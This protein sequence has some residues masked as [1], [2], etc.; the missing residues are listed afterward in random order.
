MKRSQDHHHQD[1]AAPQASRNV[2][3]PHHEH[4]HGTPDLDW[5]S[6]APFL[7]NEAEALASV[8]QQAAARVAE[9]R[10]AAGIRRILDIGSG[11]GVV[12]C[13]L[14]EAFPEAEV[15]AVDSTPALLERTRERAQRLGVAGRV[16]TLKAEV[17]GQ[18]DEL[19]QADLI[20]MGNSL[21]HIGD[22]RAALAA[23]AGLLRPGGALLLVEG[24][25]RARHLP[26]DFGIGRTGLEARL[27]AV[28][29]E[30]FA[31]MRASLP[32]AKEEI[33]DWAQLFTDAGLEPVGTRSY[34]ADHPAPIGASV[35]ELAIAGF[36]RRRDSMA[37]RLSR[38]DLA[39]LDRLL[40]PADPQ[41]LANRPDVFMLT[42][43]SVHIGL[44][45][46]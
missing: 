45:K 27:E 15:V 10:P 32:G 7:E 21:H 24:G 37:D 41:G 22:Q 16:R 44:A 38:E 31:D 2:H 5:D 33:E 1:P 3:A 8:Y 39:T 17:P 9:L 14:A 11:P 13:L 43:R 40:D 6:I 28:T 42:A 46:P 19:G 30:W 29:E 4:A 26:R 20:W 25:L 36:A 12:S 35:R 23:L 34:L 18:I